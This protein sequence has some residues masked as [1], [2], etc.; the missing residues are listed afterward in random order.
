MS[1][2]QKAQAHWNRG[3]IRFLRS[4]RPGLE[5][6][7]NNIALQYYFF[8]IKAFRIIRILYFLLRQWV[9]YLVLLAEEPCGIIYDWQLAGLPGIR[10]QF[11]DT[12]K[13]IEPLFPCEEEEEEDLF[14]IQ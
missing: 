12:F 2:L 5:K 8:R 1:L 3:D 13:P 9:S 6:G 4:L 14:R 10:V 7:K 11:L